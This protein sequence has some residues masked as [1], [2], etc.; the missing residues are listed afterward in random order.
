M[1]CTGQCSHLQCAMLIP[2]VMTAVPGGN[3]VQS[4]PDPIARIRARHLFSKK[5]TIV[6]NAFANPP[7]AEQIRC[8]MLVSES[9]AGDAAGQLVTMQQGWCQ[10]PR[11][12]L[13]PH[14]RLAVVH[15]KYWRAILHKDKLIE[16]RSSK[17]LLFAL[18]MRHQRLTCVEPSTYLGQ[19]PAL[20]FACNLPLDKRLRLYTSS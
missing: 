9:S 10:D 6:Q 18:A 3:A 15:E 16:F 7:E 13:L 12:F 11:Y 1:L 19:Q 2:S 4:S 5:V 14:M 8:S 20:H 17:R